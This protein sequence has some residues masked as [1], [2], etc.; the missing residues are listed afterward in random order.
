ML[1]SD[2]ITELGRARGFRTDDF[3][4]IA[5]CHGPQGLWLRTVEAVTKIP[6]PGYVK[7]MIGPSDWDS[8][9]DHYWR[10]VLAG[11]WDKTWR[12]LGWDRKK[13]GVA[14]VAVGTVVVAGITLGLA[15]MITT[16]TGYFW[17]IAPVAFAAFILFAWGFIETQATLYADLSKTTGAKISELEAALAKT[18]EPPPPDYSAWRHVDE[19]TLRKA[20]FLWCDLEPGISV[21]SPKVRAWLAALRAAVKKGE[22]DFVLK[23]SYYGPDRSR[24][25]RHQMEN[26][27]DDTVVKRSALQQ[28]AKKHGYDPIFLRDA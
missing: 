16:A 14:L 15:A 27:Y 22:L 8:R 19:L 11:A 28:F 4:V 7:P 24:Q 13:V 20:A 9:M 26:P 2:A 5:S 10:S 18:E 25:R 1:Y 21:P 12:P 23:Y 3:F 6:L 17:A